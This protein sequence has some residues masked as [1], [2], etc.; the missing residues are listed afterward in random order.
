MEKN[1][2]LKDEIDTEQAGL[3]RSVVAVFSSHAEADAADKTY[4]LS[5]TKLK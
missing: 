4:W 3:D 5:W 2:E 1:Q